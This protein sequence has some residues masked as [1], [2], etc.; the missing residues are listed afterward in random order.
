MTWDARIKEMLARAERDLAIEV[1]CRCDGDLERTTVGEHQPIVS[2]FG[3]PCVLPD[4]T[5]ADRC[6]TCGRLWE[7]VT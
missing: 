3:G 4:D 5:P 7:V 6:V 2:A 1:F